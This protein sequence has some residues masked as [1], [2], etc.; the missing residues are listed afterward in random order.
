MLLFYFIITIA[1][2]VIVITMIRDYNHKSN[3][4][5]W[6]FFIYSFP[7]TILPIKLICYAVLTWA[8]YVFL[9]LPILLTLIQKL[10]TPIQV[11][12]FLGLS[13]TWALLSLLVLILARWLPLTLQVLFGHGSLFA[14]CYSFTPASVGLLACLPSR[15][16]I[17]LINETITASLQTLLIWMD[18]YI[19]IHNA[20]EA[21]L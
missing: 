20:C 17:V 5:H 13:L 2:I 15:Q 14:P 19:T 11:V 9:W 10:L 18:P 3:C 4:S 16:P 1:Y 12:C 21:Q 7:S 8:C 6:L